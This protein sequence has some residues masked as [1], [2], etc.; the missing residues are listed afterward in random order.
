MPVKVEI[1]AKGGHERGTLVVEPAID[2]GNLLVTVVGPEGDSCCISID[3]RE[4]EGAVIML[5]G[6]EEACDA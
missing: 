3:G 6:L 4:L 5:V 1:Q 2:N